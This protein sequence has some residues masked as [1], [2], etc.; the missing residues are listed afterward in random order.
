MGGDGG[1]LDQF[2]DDLLC[3]ARIE[4]HAHLGELYADIGIHLRANLDGVEEPVVDVG[5][6]AG[7][8]RSGDV[9][10]QAVEGGEDALAPDCL[11]R[12][13]HLVEG[14]AGDKAGG[15]AATQGRTFGE[16]F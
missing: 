16:V 13:D 6:V 2:S 4:V 5:G 12:V 1:R 11:G 9:F 3:Q 14:H 15:H 10:A 7:F 8:F